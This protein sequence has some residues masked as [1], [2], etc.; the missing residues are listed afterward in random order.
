MIDFN[1]LTNLDLDKLDLSSIIRHINLKEYQSYI[2]A[3]S[4]QEHYR[5]LAWIS[6]RYTNVN[7]FDIGTYLGCSSIA[8]GYNINNK[9]ISYDIIDNK[10]LI[11]HPNNCIYEIGD[12]RQDDNILLSPCILIDVDP[13]DG[14]Q[15]E[16]FHNFFIDNNYKGL[17]IWDDIYLSKNM[18]MWWNSIK[19]TDSIHKIDLTNLGH[20]S[21][22][23]AIVYA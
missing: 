2:N 12:F 20:W 21:G 15:E 7:I 16:I 4:G 8:L 1:T 10:K 18:T 19:E 23:G 13:H 11:S 17:V 14:I 9:V 3:P 5:L 22:T 6:L